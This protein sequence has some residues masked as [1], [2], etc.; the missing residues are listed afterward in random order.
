MTCATSEAVEVGNCP[1]RLEALRYDPYFQW[2]SPSE[3]VNLR[4]LSL[5]SITYRILTSVAH[6]RLAGTIK[7]RFVRSKPGFVDSVAVLLISAPCVR[8]CSTAI[9]WRAIVALFFDIKGAF[10]SADQCT[11]GTLY[12]GK[13]CPNNKQIFSERFTRVARAE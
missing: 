11:F 13:V 9:C 4:E 10:N 3:Y 1:N 6:H 12:S 7:V 5:V 8:C 2:G